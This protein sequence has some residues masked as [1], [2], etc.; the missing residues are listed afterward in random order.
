MNVKETSQLTGIPA[1]TIRY[2]EKEGL[3]PKIDRN[4]VGNREIDEKIIRRLTFAKNMRAA[5][6]S[7]KALREYIRLVDEDRD[8][9]DKQKAV[10]REQMTIML[11]KRADID[12][13]VDHLQYKLDHYEDHLK[14]TEEGWRD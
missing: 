14:K 12:Y 9:T 11:A 2:Y 4:E 3:I 5:G 6:M 1:D 13:A 10:L 8:N 7:V